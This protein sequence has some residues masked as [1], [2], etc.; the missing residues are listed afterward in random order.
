MLSERGWLLLGA[1]LVGQPAC[2]SQQDVLKTLCGRLETCVDVMPRECSVRL[3]DAVEDRRL[4]TAEVAKCADCV[5]SNSCSEVLR[6]RD[7]DRP[8]AAINVVLNARTTR[9]DRANSCHLVRTACLDQAPDACE[10]TLRAELEK[11]PTLA[12]DAKIAACL[13]CLDEPGVASAAGMG[14]QAGM[15]SLGG[16]AGS[17]APVG[18]AAG[19]VS[20]GVAGEGAMCPFSSGGAGSAG[21][22]NGGGAGAGAG[23]AGAPAPTLFEGLAL[24]SSLID[25]CQASCDQVPALWTPLERAAGALAVCSRDSSCF[26][27][28]NDGRLGEGGNGGEG[29]GGEAGDAK[30]A[31]SGGGS[32]G[33]GGT[34]GPA[35]DCGPEDPFRACYQRLYAPERANAVKNCAD[36]LSRSPD[37]AEAHESCS[38]FCGSLL[39]I[40]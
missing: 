32:G 3:A 18:N 23:L 6:G 5:A 26:T 14:G 24:C 22:M 25:R 7:C 39:P 1:L 9:D 30:G 35:L 38:G 12:I 19:G 11:D 34:Q 40:Q 31:Q 33:S 10:S 2:R 17:R 37:C 36:C 28:S 20:A 21:R 15:T 4:S 13:T 8:C 29:E 16:A 27:P